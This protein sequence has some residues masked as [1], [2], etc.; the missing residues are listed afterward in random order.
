[1]GGEPLWSTL[2]CTVGI[3]ASACCVSPTSLPS[4]QDTSLLCPRGHCV[5]RACL[6]ILKGLKHLRLPRSL[7]KSCLHRES[8]QI[9]LRKRSDEGEHTASMW[10]LVLL[11][12]RCIGTACVG[13][14]R[15]LRR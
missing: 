5:V 12:H 14:A 1:M 6:Y 4:A 13:N 7:G 10:N 2:L 8:Q 9:H 3:A 15:A 11:C